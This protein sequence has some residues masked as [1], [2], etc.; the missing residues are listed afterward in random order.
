MVTATIPSPNLAEEFLDWLVCGHIQDVLAA[1][2]IAGH[3]VRLSDPPVPLRIQ[4]VYHFPN[5]E[6]LD[7]YLTNHAPRLRADGLRRF[8]PERGITFERTVGDIVPIT[9]QAGSPQSR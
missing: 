4:A 7:S 2:A 6:A 1:G 8:P 3:A 5:R 9:S